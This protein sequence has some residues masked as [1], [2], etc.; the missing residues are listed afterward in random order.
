MA[1]KNRNQSGKEVIRKKELTDLPIRQQE[2]GSGQANVMIFEWDI[3]AEQ[4]MY[5]ENWKKRFG[6]E[7]AVHEAVQFFTSSPYIHQED[8]KRFEAFLD[9]IK[10][11]RR[12]CAIQLRV[13]N[14]DLESEYDWYRIHAVTLYDQAE[15]P[16][17]VVGI[18][19]DISR[20][21]KSIKKLRRRAERDALTGLYNRE[22]TDMLV[23]H[24]LQDMPRQQC[25][26]FMID[27]DNFKQINDTNGHML[28]DVVLTEIASGMKRLMREI[29]VVGRIG[30]DEFAIFMKNISSRES[31]GQKAEKLLDMFRH[32]FEDE[33]R[34]LHVTCSIGAAMYPED[35]KDFKTLY[36]CADQALYMAKTQGKDRYVM[37]DKNHSIPVDE[38]GYSSLGT[39]IDSEQ[40][41]GGEINSFV[42]Y[43]F[44]L[45][46]KI[47]DVDQAVN[48][49]LELAGKRFD[50]SR[51]Y[52]FE[53][54]EDGLYC[55]N[56][57]EWCNN[58]ISPEIDHLQ[59]MK[60]DEWNYESMFENNS[61]F[62]CRDISTLTPDLVKLFEDQGIHS[63]L[64]CAFWEESRFAG[65][66][67]FDECTGVRLWTQEEI[68][69]LTLIS[70]ILTTFLQKRRLQERSRENLKE[71]EKSIVDCIKLLTSSEYLED[72]IEYVLQIVQD[73][74]Q[75]DRVYI[76]ETDESRGVA[77][78][79]HEICAEG[80]EPQIDKL[81]D[82][83]IEAISFWMDQFK[84]NIYVKIDD[85]ETLGEDR[86]LEY[87]I[88]KEQGINSLMAVPLYVKG[89]IKGFLGVDDPKRNR[90]EVYHLKEL[91]C[92]LENEIAKNSLKKSLEKLSCQ[93]LM[94]GL[95]N[96]NSYMAYCDEFYRRFPI[97]VGV[98]FMDI[99][100]LKKMND[101]KGH[102]YGDMVIS[103]I[104]EVMKAFFPNERKF[105]ISG[106]EFLIVTE[107]ME[108]EEFNRQLKAMSEKLH[109]DGHS[110]VSIGTT[111][112]DVHCDLNEL[113][114][115]SDKLM[116]MS[117]QEY[118]KEKGD[119]AAEKIPL[120]KGLTE[121]ILSREFMVYLQ[122][123]FNIY[124]NRVD[125][126][127]V[128]VRYKNDS[129]AVVPPVKFI[130]LLEREGLISNLDF[131][132]LNE[133]CRLFEK[134]NGTSLS[135]MRLAVNFSRITLFDEHFRAQFQETLHR[136]NI[137]PQQL[138]IEITE[139]QETLNKKQM[140]AL[141]KELRAQ[142]IY[143][144]LDDFG[145]E[146][147]SY[148]FLMMAD[149][150]L[151]KI[152]K[153]IIQRYQKARN[154]EA[155]VKHIVELSHEIGA[156]CCGEGIE[157]EEQFQ[158][159]RETG[160]DYI[161]GYFIDKPMPIELFELK[162]GKADLQVK[163][164]E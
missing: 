94:T 3:A 134:W 38:V 144:A 1:E 12:Y 72:S 35:G 154:G 8:K 9:D 18:V 55:S 62:Y 137:K 52:I 97:H 122:P 75:S 74:Y 164:E 50:V 151:L 143:I 36:K 136:Y 43:V 32:L 54:T 109:E 5:S 106:D 61:V 67:G 83:T 7:P 53:N 47:E 30:G 24:H 68:G 56:T 100:G 158:F 25:A 141:L 87:E 4:I 110:I 82:V 132:V 123:K 153:S 59:N 150:D 107:S 98:V 140:A 77:S 161:Q 71:A 162:Y 91:S 23:R 85:V 15:K 128:L 13:A 125:S 51:A 60:I 45:I 103:Y 34:T 80:I 27:T 57:Y 21:M 63:T 131:F 104:A 121:S 93:D 155:L 42:T 11:G 64:Q 14:K 41:A 66:I 2:S 16:V 99:N 147:S 31:A 73:Y 88:L 102:V 37:Y 152:D 76:I 133:V 49:I 89:E 108:Y 117:K 124:T 115:K 111:W 6:C 90:D 120:L 95:E 119:I 159:M 44:D 92:F 86:K 130:P 114:N 26:L 17:K 160:C 29:D 149:F 84:A 33:K 148:E 40:L 129:G 19:S 126:A 20:E 96:R 46:H 139:T 48:L 101:L 22:E 116:Y 163:R 157:T 142:G 145:V 69:M 58:G 70:K 118:Y 113:L 156:K 39:V 135:D 65:F 79:S 127:E 105:R 81:Q 78:I 138:E 112:S 146:Y 28:G 10:N